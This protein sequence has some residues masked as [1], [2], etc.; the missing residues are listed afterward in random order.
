MAEVRA[1]WVLFRPYVTPPR[2]WLTLETDG[3]AEVHHP[4]DQGHDEPQQDEE[5]PVLP[6]PR[7][8]ELLTAD[9]ADCGDGGHTQTCRIRGREN[10]HANTNIN[11][12]E[13][14]QDRAPPPA[15]N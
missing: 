15:I 5:D 11:Q 7:D 6:D 4:A 2:P 10:T 9:R 1:L 14:N 8:Q 3:D 13:S 12:S